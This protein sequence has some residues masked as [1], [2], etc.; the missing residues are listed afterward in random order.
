MLGER[1]LHHLVEREQAAEAFRLHDE[2][3]D[4]RGWRRRRRV[5][6]HV[7]ADPLGAVPFDD[8]LGRIPRLAAQIRAGPVVEN[9]PVR[10]P[11]PGPARRDALLARVARV[12]ARHL[13]ALLGVA[14]RED[15]AAGRG[16][17]V[18][19][20]LREAVELLPGLEGRL[21]GGVLEVGQR[22]AVHLL[23]ELLGIGIDRIDVVPGEVQERIGKRAAVLAIHFAQAMEEPSHDPDVG[24]RFA[25]RRRRLPVPL[26]P[27]R[28]IDERAVLFGEAGGRKLEHLRLDRGRIGRIVRT[29]I[30]PE[31]RRLR[32]ERVHHHEVFE[33]AESTADL[34]L[35]REGLERVE[36]LA[37][38]AVHLAVRHHLE[39]LDD[40]VERNVEF[41]QPVIGPVVI[42]CRGVRRR[43]PSG[44]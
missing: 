3:A 44:S 31:A 6:G 10:R 15:P 33:F 17:T 4:P 19:A 43:S 32:V 7:D 34:A 30:L 12:A 5:V 28:R 29:E 8:R 22:P 11:R 14:A 24:L 37:D 1:S 16:R 23:G 20:Q 13:V 35:V 40:V 25:R 21:A 41:R 42:G 2:G 18:I 39:S 9:A 26:Q 38:V 27:A 36:A